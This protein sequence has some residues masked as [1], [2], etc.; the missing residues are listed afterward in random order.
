MSIVAQQT[1]VKVIGNSVAIPN[2]P[3]AKLMYYLSCCQAVTT[4]DFSPLSNYSQY[5]LMGPQERDLILK[6]ASLFSPDKMINGGP[7]MVMNNLPSNNEFFEINEKKFEYH[8]VTSNIS[9]GKFS[10]KVKKLMAARQS[11][12]QTYYYEPIHEITTPKPRVLYQVGP[13]LYLL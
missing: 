3:W 10:G 5:H 2:D 4:I 12:Y 11:W 6:A 9:F 1:G 7:F 13:F 8:Q